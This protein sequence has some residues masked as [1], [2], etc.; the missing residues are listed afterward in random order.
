M[1]A[2]RTVTRNPRN[3]VVSIYVLRDG[4]P[5]PRAVLRHSGRQ[6]GCGVGASFSW[7]GS[8][9]LYSATDGPA[10]IVD[11]RDGSVRS[12][13]GFTDR[14]PRSWPGERVTAHWLN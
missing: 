14:L 13:S 10:A 7:R 11:S 5:R 6:K 8:S 9:F 2:F 1:F 4:E 12:L 3:P